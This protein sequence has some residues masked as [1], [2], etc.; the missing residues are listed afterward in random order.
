MKVE[1]GESLLYSWL[2]HTKECKLVQSNWKASTQWNLLHKKELE[3]IF[4]KTDE[5]FRNKYSYNI[6]KKNSSVSQVI[7]QGECDVLGISVGDE[8]NKFYAVDVAFH[9]FGLNYGSKEETV[10]KVVSKIV[11]TAICLYGYFNTKKAEI[12]FAAPKINNAVMEKLT[13]CISDLND[14]FKTMGYEF[15]IKVIAN[16]SFKT[17]VLEPVIKVSDEVED[18]SELFVRAYQLYHMFF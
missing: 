6:F 18:T 15:D 14:I 7:Q 17:E 10:M 4:E 13:P 12:I 5:Y 3:D 8:G 2:R 1:V 16:D 9:E 11:R